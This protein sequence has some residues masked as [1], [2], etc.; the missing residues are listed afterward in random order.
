MID[1]LF[2]RL[3]LRGSSIAVL[4]LTVLAAG[5]GK[6]D[7]AGRLEAAAYD[8]QGYPWENNELGLTSEVPEPWSPVRRNGG[9]LEVWGRTYELG[10][11]VLPRQVTTQ[12]QAVFVAEPGL[13]VVVDG[14]AVTLGEARVASTSDRQVILRSSASGE[15]FEMQASATLE[16]DGLWLVDLEIR[17]KGDRIRLDELTLRLPLDAGLAQ[18]FSRYLQYDYLDQV[19]DRDDMGN[20][21]GALDEAVALPF[22]PSVWFGN[23][24][25]GIEWICE[26]DYGWSSAEGERDAVI[27]A[28]PGEGLVEV[29]VKVVSEPVELGEVYRL[30]FGLYPTPVKPLREDWRLKRI[31]SQ[32]VM[33]GRLDP[34]VLDVY[35]IIMPGAVPLKYPGLPVLEASEPD[36]LSLP[37]RPERTWVKEPVKHV[38]QTVERM[39]GKGVH[40]VIYGALNFMPAHMPRG[41]WEHYDRLWRTHPKGYD[42]QAREGVNYERSQPFRGGGTNRTW[43]RA[44]NIPDDGSLTILHVSPEHRSYRDFIVWNYV[45]AIK[46]YG[47]EGLYFDAGAPNVMAVNPDLPYGEHVQNGGQHYPFFAQRRLMQ[48]LWVACKGLDPDFFMVGHNPKLPAIISAYYDM[49]LTGE[50]LTASFRSDDW[51][52]A[53]AGEDLKAYRPDYSIFPEWLFSI[54]YAHDAFGTANIMLPMVLADNHRLMQEHPELS[55]AYT[56]SMLAR[57]MVYDIPFYPANMDMPMAEEV[58]KALQRFRWLKDVAFFGPDESGALLSSPADPLRVAIYLDAQADEVM[59]VASNLGTRDFDG[60]LML[61][62]QSLKAHGVEVDEIGGWID[63]FSGEPHESSDAAQA[64]RLRVPAND[65]AMFIV[66]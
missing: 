13:S 8:E 55:E 56:R 10:A 44:Q 66:R 22:N 14:R 63:A 11:G 46:R 59:V 65:F 62:A 15:G 23:R 4:A 35:G 58:G 3:V 49:A 43:G 29:V 31:V 17:P 34:K 18:V 20:S 45:E 19:V 24:G 41:E 40:F 64:P 50:A 2:C 53:K 21:Y 51:S 6:A 52:S 57:T 28:T 12:G 37:S 36:Q 54:G 48:R 7:D 32:D 30:R 26:T 33:P 16:Y 42:A 27:E 5:A 60:R 39:R 1:I 25:G 38:Q 47:I 9:A 61:D